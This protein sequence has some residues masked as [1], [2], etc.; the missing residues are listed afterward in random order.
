M[1]QQTDKQVSTSTALSIAGYKAA[2][3]L[4]LFSTLLIV[5]GV[6]RTNLYDAVPTAAMGGTSM[7]FPPAVLLASGVCL[8]AMGFAGLVTGFFHLSLN[9]RHPTFTLIM[10]VLEGVLGWFVFLSQNIAYH[11]FVADKNSSTSL[12][13]GL[14]MTG[15][16]GS[17]ALG[18]AALG[19]QFYFS[20]QLYRVHSQGEAA[21]YDR[22]YIRPRVVLYS[23]LVIMKASCEIAMGVVVDQKF[24]GVP[25][26]GPSTATSASITQS[27][28]QIMAGMTQS[29]SAP[30]TSS[31]SSDMSTSGPGGGSNT[32]PLVQPPFMSYKYKFL[33]A[34]GCITLVVGLYGLAVGL[35]GLSKQSLY[36]AIV[37]T[38]SLIMQLGLYDLAQIAYSPMASSSSPVD[39]NAALRQTTLGVLLAP[40][41]VALMYMPMYLVAEMDS[42]EDRQMDLP[43]NEPHNSQSIVFPTST[44]N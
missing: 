13:K 20:L 42:D 25:S 18:I 15:M 6:A 39:A 36:F 38:A 28:S 40:L 23:F 32:N 16:F 12:Q 31:S 9:I 5:F 37:A 33:I 35:A 4:I 29:Y 44:E 41:T 34:D 26:S 17:A 11:A 22:N 8:C 21:V 10:L 1:L 3:N 43:Q 2:A 14:V 24:M 19:G 27:V 30:S 7:I